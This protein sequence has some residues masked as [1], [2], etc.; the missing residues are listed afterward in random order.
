MT[1]IQDAFIEGGRE[2]VLISPLA[3]SGGMGWRVAVRP[4]SNNCVMPLL[5]RPQGISF[6]CWT[7]CCKQVG[8]HTVPQVL[9]WCLKECPI[10][11]TEGSKAE[12]NVLSLFPS[13][14][15]VSV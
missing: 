7:L 8:R 2:E 3:T 5:C 14:M 15:T 10:R 6:G 11:C 12:I 4:W 13:I 1:V 9:N